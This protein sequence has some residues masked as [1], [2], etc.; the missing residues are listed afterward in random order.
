MGLGVGV[1]ALVA[2]Y[3]GAERP[4]LAERATY[5]A[6]RVSLVYMAVCAI[7][8]VGLPQ[9]LLAPFAA[10]SSPEAFAPVGATTEVLLRYVALYSV[11]D[12]FNVIFASGLRGA[13]DTAYTFKLTFVLSG[14]NTPV[15]RSRD[16][17]AVAATSTGSQGVVGVGAAQTIDTW[18]VVAVDPRAGTL[19]LVNPKS[20][21]VRTYLVSEAGREQLPRVKVGDSLTVVRGPASISTMRAALVSIDRNSSRSVWRAISAS[22]PASST[23]VGPPPTSTNVSS[24]RCRAASFSRSARSKAS[25]IRRRISS[26]SSSVFNPCA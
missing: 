12:M 20:G 9:L 16:N 22:V 13:G 23:P 21:P 2:R 3:L 7:G 1:S 6:L 8:Y 25:R 19:S 11:F 10:G 14:P 4:D 18:W 5:S 24:S 17:R 15:P 26:A